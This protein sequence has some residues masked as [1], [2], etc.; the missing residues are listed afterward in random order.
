VTALGC[1]EHALTA[2]KLK[3]LNLTP[4]DERAVMARLLAVAQY[5]VNQEA[6]RAIAIQKPAKRERGRPKDK[7]MR[8]VFG[9]LVGIWIDYAQSV[10]G[11]SY[12][13]IDDAYRGKFVEFSQMFCGT[14]A[15]TLENDPAARSLVRSLR[16]VQ[17]HSVRVRTWLR[18]IGVPQFASYTD[19]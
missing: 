18:A 8:E 14:L 9:G 15:D 16:D 7:A 10:P 5:V 4:E 6:H 11:V 19:R 13:A 12:F 3:G 17:K 1:L 2:L